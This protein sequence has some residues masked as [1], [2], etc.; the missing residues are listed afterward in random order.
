MCLVHYR[1]I[2]ANNISDNNLE[3][4]KL[5]F[6]PHVPLV[7]LGWLLVFRP[8]YFVCDH[9]IDLNTLIVSVTVDTFCIVLTGLLEQCRGY[10]PL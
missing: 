8:I 5:L 2:Y 6:I 7:M 4:M 9:G 3:V 10:V 1:Q